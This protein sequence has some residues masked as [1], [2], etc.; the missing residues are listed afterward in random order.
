MLVQVTPESTFS[1]VRVSPTKYLP[2]SRYTVAGFGR[3]R[4]SFCA[5]CNVLNGS[6]SVPAPLSFPVVDMYISVALGCDSGATQGRSAI[7]TGISILPGQS[8][9]FSASCS[10]AD[11]DGTYGS[12]SV[13]LC[14][15]EITCAYTLLLSRSSVTSVLYIRIFHAIMG[16]RTVI[17]PTSLSSHFPINA[18][19]LC[20]MTMHLTKSNSPLAGLFSH[21]EF[22]VCV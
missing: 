11:A 8:S 14:T 21:T 9:R 4:V 18:I 10:H 1:S 17:D 3:L 16:G 22:E 19:F 12:H 5:L 15:S 13:D 7:S 20:Y 2:A 6:F